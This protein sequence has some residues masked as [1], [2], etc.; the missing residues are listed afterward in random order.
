MSSKPIVIA[1]IV[2]ILLAAAVLF[3]LAGRGGGRSAGGVG[4]VVTVG[5]ALMDLD[6][7]KV[8]RMSVSIDGRDEDV[9]ERGPDGVLWSLRIKGGGTETVWPADFLRIRVFLRELSTARATG[10]PEAGASI[11]ASPP[12]TSVELTLDDGSRRTL[13][14]AARTLGGQA[15]VEIT[16]S[17]AK[18]GESAVRMAVVSESLL[19]ALTEPGP[20]GWRETQLLP[21]VAVG[22]TG[23]K[24][25][26]ASSGSVRV[27]R[28][29]G[30]WGLT[31]PVVGP[32]DQAAV[33]KMLSVLESLR[34]E[35]FV[36]GQLSAKDAGLEKP[37]ATAAIDMETRGAP[38]PDGAPVVKPVRR[39]LRIGG[40]ADASG[41][42]LYAKFDG[43][44][45]VVI[46][47]KA[48]RQLTIDP[49]KLLAATSV[50]TPAADIGLVTVSPSSGA[51]MRVKRTVRGW[52]AVGQDEGSGELLLDK[53]KSDEVESLVT[54]LTKTAAVA[55]GIEQPNGYVRGGVVRLATV[56]GQPLE[57]VEYGAGEG[58]VFV[59]R[60][61]SAWRTYD[62]K[63]K[64]VP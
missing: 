38:G 53:A 44:P 57:E 29:M 31:E 25:T 61:G 18:P 40:P 22:A 41:A 64:I 2:C 10:K 19:R 11:P 28:V 17:A 39:E 54:Q 36:D 42:N 27:Q 26:T 14:F 62:A 21:G 55:I 46:D 33:G 9:L 47:A 45:P 13:R 56:G 43:G 35:R 8:S 51:A 20:R 50:Q 1:L 23:L 5:D 63:P 30:R 4:P 60:V 15:K 6:I 48:L 34:V 16:D 32:A 49:A 58:A 12:P 37:A 24:L 59:A 7:Q 52:A 3:T